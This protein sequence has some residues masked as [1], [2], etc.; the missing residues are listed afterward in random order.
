MKNFDLEKI[1]CELNNFAKVRDW[2]Q[3]HTPKNL[4]VALSVEA[5]ELLELFQWLSDSEIKEVTNNPEKMKKINE[6]VADVAIYLIRFCSI[7]NID[8]EQ[9]IL[10]KIEK[11]GKKYPLDKAKGSNKKYTEF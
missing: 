3:F 6:E 10:A 7:L 2:E 9:A 4:S 1:A 5:S 11:N 8:L